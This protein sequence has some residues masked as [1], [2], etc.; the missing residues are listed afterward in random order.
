MNSE[1]MKETACLEACNQLHE[2]GAL[3]HNLQERGN[4]PYIEMQPSYFPP[5]LVGH[6]PKNSNI[7]YHCYLM[8][9][10]QKFDI[11]LHDI[12]LVLR[13][14]LESELESLHFDLDVDRGSLPVNF[15]YVGVLNL[16]KDQV[17]LCTRFQKTLL[18]VLRLKT[19]NER[20]DGDIL[21][22]ETDYLLLP[23]C[24]TPFS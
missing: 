12:V 8:E 21:G 20:M 1:I 5:E 14:K 2:I 10:E 18:R 16:S 11:P 13:N 6:V 3:R 17:H 24:N 23:A 19:F 9:L 22:A 7:L 4:E 15:K